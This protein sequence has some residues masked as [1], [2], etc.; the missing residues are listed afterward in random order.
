MGF[1]DFLSEAA[2]GAGE[3]A[4]AGPLGMI[5]GAIRG[6]FGETPVEKAQA[7][8]AKAQ[9]AQEELLQQGLSEART[10]GQEA[11]AGFSPY[12]EAGRLALEQQQAL[13]GLL[14]PE[15]QQAAIAQLE[16]SPQFQAMLQQGEQAILANAAATGGLR[17]G[18]TQ[19]MLAQFRPQLLSSLIQQQYERLGGMSAAGQRGAETGAQTRLG[20]AGLA[21]PFYEQIGA[22]R[23]GGIMAPAQI[24]LASSQRAQQAISD[25]TT[26]GAQIATSLLAPV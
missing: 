10:S 22:S 3:Y 13:A 12:A 24:G 7:A 1:F 15:A 11:V 17:G 25:Q 9:K 18:N 5:Y 2:E 6:G 19:A 23:A 21:S 20:F 8:A 16:A 14:G 4:A 26:A